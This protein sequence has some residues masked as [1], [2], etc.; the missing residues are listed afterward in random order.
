MGLAL[1]VSLPGEA[2][3]EAEHF[4]PKK[5]NS[6]ECVKHILDELRGAVQQRVLFQKRKLL[7]DFE[8]VKRTNQETARQYLNRYPRIE[9][10]LDNV[11]IQSSAMNDAESRGNRVL[12]RCLLSD[13]LQR[14]VLIG[15]GNDLHYE[16]SYLS[17]PEPLLAIS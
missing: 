5:V 17:E 7:S 4:D 12:E 8:N 13:E 2:V 15:A 11:G 3:S 16:K 1:Y 9:R 10:D 6:K 14:L